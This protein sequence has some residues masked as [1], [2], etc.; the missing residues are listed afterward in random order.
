[1]Q[2]AAYQNYHK[3]EVEGASKGKIVLL[4][5]EGAIRF[6]R[7]AAKGIE[8]KN[9]QE[10]HN[11]IIKAENIIYELMS[12][13]NMEAGEIAENLMRLYDFII[14][15]LV[16]ANKDKDKDKLESAINLL[17]PLRDAWKEITDKGPVQNAQHPQTALPT[18]QAERKSIN[19]AG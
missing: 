15:Q 2:T 14:W 10:A 11:N 3:Q 9:I 18:E 17:S 4:L 19:F 12:T 5:I 16:E 7:R 8:E 6:L 13:L 1:M